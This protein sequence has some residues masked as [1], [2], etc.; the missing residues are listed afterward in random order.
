MTRSGFACDWALAK[1]GRTLRIDNYELT[2][3]YLMALYA[4]D[5]SNLDDVRSQIQQAFVAKYIQVHGKQLGI[6]PARAKAS[7]LLEQKLQ[8]FWKENCLLHR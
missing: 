3:A 5:Q 8:A 1:D 6:A 4:L 7:G 2:D